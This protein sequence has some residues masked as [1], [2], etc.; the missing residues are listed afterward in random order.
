[1]STDERKQDAQ[2]S[3]ART[4]PPWAVKAAVVLLWV[5]VALNALDLLLL[6]PDVPANDGSAGT[7]LLALAVGVVVAVVLSVLLWRGVRWARW[8]AGVY[9][10]LGIVVNAWGALSGPALGQLLMYVGSL[11]VLALAVN[12]LFNDED[13]TRYFARR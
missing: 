7:N 3:P 13:T 12:Y 9:L 2:G 11:L 8:A 1:M 4:G 6:S 10:V 5:N